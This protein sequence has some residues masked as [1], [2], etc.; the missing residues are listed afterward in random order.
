M[1]EKKVQV[2]ANPFGGNVLALNQVKDK[3][4]QRKGSLRPLFDCV[5]AINA[6]VDALQTFVESVPEP[7]DNALV[8]KMLETLT[9]MQIKLLDMSRER[10]RKQNVLQQQGVLPVEGGEP[11]MDQSADV[12]AQEVQPPSVAA[13]TV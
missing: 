9:S 1:I 10:I 3:T 4:T 5:E 13:P 2:A 7:N 11:G 6:A 8:T 12:G